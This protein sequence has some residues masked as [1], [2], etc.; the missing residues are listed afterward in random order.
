ME[1]AQFYC[2]ASSSITRPI[3]S[4][5]ISSYPLTFIRW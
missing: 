3:F 4:S 1:Y 2:M 5:F